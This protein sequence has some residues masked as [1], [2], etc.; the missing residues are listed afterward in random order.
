[1]S[2]G[3]WADRTDIFQA[4]VNFLPLYLACPTASLFDRLLFSFTSP[5]ILF[6]DIFSFYNLVLKKKPV[7][8]LSYPLVQ[9]DF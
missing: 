3:N 9:S 1:M 2:T 6:A 7:R 4:C 5:E 8:P